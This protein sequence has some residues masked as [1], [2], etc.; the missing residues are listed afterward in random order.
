MVC[1]RGRAERTIGADMA[2]NAIEIPESIRREHEAIHSALVAGIVD[3]LEE[4][5][6]FIQ[7]VDADAPAKVSEVVA[8]IETL[9]TR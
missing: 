4:R 2:S 9:V 8:R 5:A 7:V 1:R 6:I 3:R